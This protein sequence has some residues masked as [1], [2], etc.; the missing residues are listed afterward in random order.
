VKKRSAG[1]AMSFVG[2]R[3]DRI[4]RLGAIKHPSNC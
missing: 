4:Y 1:N 2:R 3:S